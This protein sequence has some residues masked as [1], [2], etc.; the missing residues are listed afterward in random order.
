MDKQNL[1]VTSFIILISLSIH[2]NIRLPKLIND[3]MVLQRNANVKIWGWAD[4]LEEISIKF[5]N[6]TYKTLANHKGEW[7]I[8]LKNLSVGGPY[9]MIINADNKIVVENILIGDIWVCSGQSNMNYRLSSAKSIYENEIS[10]AYNKEIRCFTV[11]E[12]YDFRGPQKDLE[13]G[14]W[15]EANPETV[16]EFSAVSYFFAAELYEKYGVPI[17]LI[18]SSKNASPAQAWISKVAI[19]EF[20]DYY[21][22]ALKFGDSSLIVKIKAEEKLRSETWFKTSKSKDEGYKSSKTWFDSSTNTANWKSMEVP[23]SIAPTPPGNT[24]G[25]YW[26]K[27]EVQIPKELVGKEAVLK[28]GSIV[29]SDSVY[30]NNIFVGTTSHKWT[31]RNYDIPTGVLK[32]GVNTITMRLVNH[33]GYGEFQQGYPYQ[34]EFGEQLIDISGAW[35]Y[36]LGAKMEQLPDSTEFRQKPTGLHNGMIAP[37]TNYTI[38]RV[39]WYQGEGNSG[40]PKEYESLFPCLIKNWRNEWNQGDFPFLFVQLANYKKTTD[41]PD[42]SNWAMLRD[43]QRKTLALPN[44]GMAVAIDIGV[45]YDVHPMNKKDV[46]YRL[47]LEAQRVAYGDK[48]V[49]SSGPLYQSMKIEGDK[50]V[51]SFETFGSSLKVKDADKLEYFEIA[52]ADRNFVWASA[53]I[54]KDKIMVSNSEVKNPVAVRYGWADNPETANLVNSEYLPASPFRTDDWEK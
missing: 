46:G 19:K 49:V 44:T 43:S 39:I 48:E 20:P 4:K 12:I 33:N 52:G 17:G 3:G 26:F 34:I 51:L 8:Q 11:P 6:E 47:A 30:I 10:Q 21:N 42:A 38:K 1:I 29:N 31:S 18:H 14:E 24:I 13:K 45:A 53:K 27:K 37:L 32:A 15:V 35:K 22:E 25:V 2:A 5:I 7:E 28:M 41:K 9:K 40:K 36:Q 23:G 16:L 54:K 50:I